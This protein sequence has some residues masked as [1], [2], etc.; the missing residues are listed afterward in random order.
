MIGDLTSAPEPVVIKLFSQDPALLEQ[1][2]PA[3]WAI[4][5]R[6]FR[7]WWTCS[8]ASRTP[9]AVPPRSSTWTRWSRRAP[10]STP[11]EVELDA[12]A[13]LQGEPATAPVV[14]NDRSYTIR[15]RFPARRAPIARRH[16]Q[17]HA[18]Q[19]HR[20]DR[21]HRLA[22]HHDRNSRPDRN[23]PRQPAAQRAGDRAF[24]KHEPGRRHDK[25][26]AGHRRPEPAAR[27]PRA[28]R[29]PVRRA[30][31]IVQGPG[32]RAGAGHRAGLHR[33]A[34]RVRQFRR[35]HRGALLPRCSPL[36]ACSWR[37]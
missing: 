2:G 11:Q 9:S 21:H 29:R 16:P 18:G 24:R 7:A 8:M 33:A 23:P 28:V 26:A 13:M 22:G 36:A 20:Q 4:P 12:S 37:C 25:G 34:V 19:R 3:R 1:L 10:D 17:H 15:V 35:A 5:S 14:V 27:H 31:E 6:R 32:F 30:A